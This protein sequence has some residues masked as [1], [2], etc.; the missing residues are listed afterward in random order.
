MRQKKQTPKEE[1]NNVAVKEHRCAHCG[2]L[3]IPK[4]KTVAGN[5]LMCSKECFEAFFNG[6]I[7][8][9]K[10]EISHSGGS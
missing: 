9:E 8:A 5:Q 4:Y 2:K 3:K 7:K 6:I 1:T 10:Y